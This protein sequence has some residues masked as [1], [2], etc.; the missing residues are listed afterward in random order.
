MPNARSQGDRAKAYRLR[1][2]DRKGE[3]GPV[4]KL[5]LAEYEE[6]REKWEKERQ[7]R[8]RPINVGASKKKR[9]LRVELDE[10]AEAAGTG[11]AAAL[12]AGALAAK[13]EGRRLDFLTTESVAALKEA[14]RVY[15]SICL[16]LRERTEILEETHVQLLMSVREH[17][18]K[19][20]EAETQLLTQASEDPANSL[21]M[22]LASRVLGVPITGLPPGGP[23]GNGA[24]P[25]RRAPPG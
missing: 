18:I 20:S 12:A 23:P 24:P 13:E 4:D 7:A 22:M 15:R 16:S 10:E 25:R 2:L 5:W 1:K 11:N 14:C 3:L 9:R 19:R 17:A 8:S 6:E 21:L